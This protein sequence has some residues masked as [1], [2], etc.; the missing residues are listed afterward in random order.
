VVLRS[1]HTP[2]SDLDRAPDEGE[3]SSSQ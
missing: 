3:G 1:G 2:L